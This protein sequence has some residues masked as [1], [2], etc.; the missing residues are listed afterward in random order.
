[1]PKSDMDPMPVTLP[2][3]I[4]RIVSDVLSA[5]ELS[6]APNEAAIS[7]RDEIERE[8]ERNGWV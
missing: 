5:E 7:A 8:L 3:A 6:A 2:V 4:W 1:M